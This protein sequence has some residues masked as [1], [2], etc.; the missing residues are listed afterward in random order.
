MRSGS[1]TDN[2]TANARSW[3]SRNEGLTSALNSAAPQESLGD[4]YASAVIVVPPG[5]MYCT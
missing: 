1:E 5:L 4:R 3:R 2:R